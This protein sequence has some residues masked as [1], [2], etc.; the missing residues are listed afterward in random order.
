MSLSRV[1]TL[2]SQLLNQDNTE[3]PANNSTFGR[4]KTERQR[5]KGILSKEAAQIFDSK[6]SVQQKVLLD[7]CFLSLS[8]I[9][10][11]ISYKD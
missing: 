9:G 1:N 3:L 11:W 10:V 4:S 2:P 8:L 6:I 7:V 5:P